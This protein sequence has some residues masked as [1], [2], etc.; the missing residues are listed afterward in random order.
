[1]EKRFGF[2]FMPE[3]Q[4]ATVSAVG[5]YRNK[6]PF[7]QSPWNSSLLPME[8]RPDSVFFS[9]L[10]VYAENTLDGIT[11]TEWLMALH[12]WFSACMSLHRWQNKIIL[13]TNRKEPLEEI[14]WQVSE[15][16]Y[17][18]GDKQEINGFLKNRVLRWKEL[19]YFLWTMITDTR[20]ELLL[21]EFKWNIIHSTFLLKT[22][23]LA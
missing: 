22:Q 18:S 6:S 14:E 13:Q 9:C 4:P 17:D 12:R 15:E 21:Q 20:T 1:M 7:C 16:H 5:T 23:R 8:T 3:R 2:I 11:G 19:G 10:F